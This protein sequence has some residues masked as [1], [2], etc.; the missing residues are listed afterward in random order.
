MIGKKSFPRLFNKNPNENLDFHSDW[1]SDKGIK[2]A[3]L[4][5]QR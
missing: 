2:F 4:E 1:L 3:L 5:A